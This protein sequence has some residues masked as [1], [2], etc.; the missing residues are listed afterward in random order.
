MSPRTRPPVPASG[1]RGVEVERV[2]I[3]VPRAFDEAFGTRLDVGPV[4]HAN[5]EPR[6]YVCAPRERGQ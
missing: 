3:A 5:G 6:T 2:E 4:K 1:L